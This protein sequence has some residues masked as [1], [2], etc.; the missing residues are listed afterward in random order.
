[1]RARL[2]IA[3]I[4]L[5]LFGLILAP[6]HVWGEG[7][8]GSDVNCDGGVN[9]LD[10]QWVILGVF[11]APLSPSQD[12]NQDGIHDN[13]PDPDVNLA[14]DYNGNGTLDVCEDTP[15][16][17]EVS[18]GG[19]PCANCPPSPSQCDGGNSGFNIPSVYAP[20]SGCGSPFVM[21]RDTVDEENMKGALGDVI[22]RMNANGVPG[23]GPASLG[24]IGSSNTLLNRFGKEVS[25]IP[26]YTGY[27]G[28]FPVG[29]GEFIER[30]F[31]FGG[32]SSSSTADFEDGGSDK[33]YWEVQGVT[34]N[35]DATGETLETFGTLI[36]GDGK[37]FLMVSFYHSDEL[38][39]GTDFPKGVRIAFID[40]TSVDG[41]GSD[42]TPKYRLFLLVSP[43]WSGGKGTFGPVLYD[44]GTTSNHAG[45]LAWFR[46]KNGSEYLYVPDTSS[47]IRVFDLNE[48][49]R[50]TETSNKKA[51]GRD[52]NDL[53]SAF[54]YQYVIPEVARYRLCNSSCCARFSTLSMDR[55][56]N[57]PALVTGEYDN[58]SDSNRVV[59]WPLNEETGLPLH[60]SEADGGDEELWVATAAFLPGVSRV[61]GALMIGEHAFITT[62]Q[63]HTEDGIYAHGKCFHA[64]FTGGTVSSD[65]CPSYPEGM[66]F[67]GEGIWTCT[68]KPGNRY[69][70]RMSREEFSSF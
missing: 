61:Q 35:H 57:P 3:S 39:D 22:S 9:V 53:Y 24:I 21:Y 13:C 27:F 66:Y 59:R 8:Y 37:R 12:A 7:F 32:S 11:G 54:G 65:V 2:H 30:A 6:T 41:S 68:E 51:I 18:C 20:V 31:R 50:V 38:G 69:C 33:D 70:V 63:S 29:N 56:S 17:A 67:D 4:S 23:D 5:A 52:S 46:G 28:S 15:L 14:A 25:S 49:L 1:M 36:P 10:V 62:T 16:V 43:S 44:G 48:T 34:G 42:D 45:G 60:Q 55:S 26:S 64:N 19:S 40:W 58:V 47:G